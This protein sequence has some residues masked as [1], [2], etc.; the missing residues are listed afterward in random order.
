MTSVRTCDAVLAQVG[1][2]LAKA[3]LIFKKIDTGLRGN[4]GAEIETLARAARCGSVIVAPSIP[5][6]GRR[7]QNGMQFQD[8][9]LLS[10][11][12]YAADP[13]NPA[14]S[15]RIAQV[16]RQTSSL[17]AVNLKP[18]ELGG[19]DRGLAVVDS[20]SDS[21][22]DVIIEAALKRKKVLLVGSLGLGAAL[23]RAL[24]AMWPRP[25]QP[26]DPIAR[27]Q[28]S[29]D[30]H[31]NIV[32]SGTK[33]K[34]SGR[35]IQNACE[36]LGVVV[37][38]TNLPCGSEQAREISETIRAEGTAVLT[39]GAVQCRGGELLDQLA[40]AIRRIVDLTG[41]SNLALIGGETAYHV[42]KTL[43]AKLITVKAV[44][45]NVVSLGRIRQGLCDGM[46]LACKGGSVGGPNAVIEMIRYLQRG[47]T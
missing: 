47:L 9:T 19:F 10:M 42:L 1:A 4:V 34:M 32:V 25:A 27:G 5:S 21:D 22:L 45:E 28:T 41:P 18:H 14:G 20:R 29:G 16:I 46:A 13:G 26:N 38:K 8:G 35:Q 30:T 6:I 24:L 37:I 7:T 23:C 39:I 17:T 31:A 33:Y 36:M 43:G 40:H 12:D 44:A 15:F 3:E 2:N 11:T